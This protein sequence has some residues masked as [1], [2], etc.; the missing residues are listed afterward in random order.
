MNKPTPQ[1]NAIDL[2]SG[3]G[4][5]SIGFTHAEFSIPLSVEQDAWA[6]ETYKLNHPKTNLLTSDIRNVSESIFRNQSGVDVVMGGP[7][8]QGF[9][10]SASNRRLKNDPRNFLYLDFLHAVAIINPRIVLIENVNEIQK[11][12]LENGKLLCV[13]I[14]ERLNKMGY[15]SAVLTL[16]AYAFGVPQFR[17]RTFI[18]AGKQINNFVFL[19]TGLERKSTD[20][21]KQRGKPKRSVNLWDAISD[22]PSVIPGTV[23]EEA[24]FPY[25][26]KPKNEYQKRMRKHSKFITNHVPMRHTPRMIERFQHIIDGSSEESFPALLTPRLR[27]N[28]Q[29]ASSKVYHQN[30]RKLLPNKPSTTI[31]AS[32]YSSFVHPFQPRNLTVREAA[33]LQSFPDTFIFKGK[34]TTLSKKLLTKKGILGDLH[35]DQFNQVGNSVPPILAEEIAKTIREML[36]Q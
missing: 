1:L 12:R 15:D 2:F 25:S 14:Q 6:S 4:G 36:S 19:A 5:M 16:N 21:L 31:T 34:R 33:R 11:Y 20:S 23:T 18:I 32:F 17:I 9:S 7:P 3:A 30:H 13:D 8:C 26:T 22:L 27:G 35:L 29:L 24:V 28:P 10:I